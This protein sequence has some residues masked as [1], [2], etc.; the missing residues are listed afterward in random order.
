MRCAPAQ[1]RPKACGLEVALT[2][3]LP[4]G[5]VTPSGRA[6]GSGSRG[7]GGAEGGRGG[8]RLEELQGWEVLLTTVKLGWPLALVV[9]PRALARYQLIFR[10]G[11]E[12]LQAADGGR[13][14][15]RVG[16]GRLGWRARKAS[17]RRSFAAQAPVPDEAHGAA[18]GG[19]VAPHAGRAE[20]RQVRIPRTV[21]WVGV[22]LSV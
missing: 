20:R 16:A 1:L 15:A 7:R 22:V 11:R 9:P 10:C 3:M 21:G 2:L 13:R 14:G 19:G 4:Q 17:E 5:G 8:T 6:A 18:A 12:S